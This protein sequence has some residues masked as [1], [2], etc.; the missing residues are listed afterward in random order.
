MFKDN[1]VDVTFNLDSC[2]FDRHDPLKAKCSI[3]SS[4]SPEAKLAN[5]S[6]ED[7]VHVLD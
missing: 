2:L 1:Y 7:P 3:G 4:R 6:L 5:S